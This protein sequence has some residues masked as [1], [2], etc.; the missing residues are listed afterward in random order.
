M[1]S[2]RANGKNWR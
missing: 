2:L 1:R